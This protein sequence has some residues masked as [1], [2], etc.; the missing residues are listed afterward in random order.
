MHRVVAVWKCQRPFEFGDLRTM[1]LQNE[2][3][4]AGELVPM[5][6]RSAKAKKTVERLIPCWE[7]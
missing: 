2:D 4:R 6:T 3:L 1:L 5:K 7:S